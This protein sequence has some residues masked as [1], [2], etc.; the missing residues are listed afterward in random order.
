[1]SLLKACLNGARTRADHPAVPQTPEELARDAEAVVTAGAQALH[2]H[3]RDA[4]GAPTLEATHCGAALRAIRRASP[5][6]LVGLTTIARIEPDPARRIAMVRAW[7]ERPDFASVNWS[8]PGAEDLARALLDMDVAV[9]AGIWTF[10]DAE[11]FAASAVAPLCLRALVEPLEPDATESLATARRVVDRLRYRG[12][13]LPLVVHGRGRATWPVLRD[14]IARGHGI[15][16]GLEDTLHLPDG[17]V[18]RVNAE[19]VAAA[20]SQRQ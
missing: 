15:R 3:A 4:A 9:E 18:A 2:V 10:D 13:R 14:A 16:V 12:V 20:R 1:M 8:E 5:G 17:R 7:T 19:L 11:R 6:V